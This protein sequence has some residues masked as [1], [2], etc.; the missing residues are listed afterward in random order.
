MVAGAAVAMILLTLTI[1]AVLSMLLEGIAAGVLA[2]KRRGQTRLALVLLAM[3]LCEPL[4]T[5]FLWGKSGSW[6]GATSFDPAE[7]P[8]LM[9]TAPA[10]MLLPPLTGLFFRAG[11]A[12]FFSARVLFV[13]LLRCWFWLYVFRI[14]QLPSTNILPLILAFV[15]MIPVYWLSAY[16]GAWEVM[17]CWLPRRAATAGAE[18]SAKAHAVAAVMLA[19]APLFAGYLSYP[20]RPMPRNELDRIERLP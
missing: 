2:W 1:P 4:V 12:R 8:W 11:W 7:I 3:N 17:I 10:A 20:G 13:G 18:P 5:A 15:L 14:M 19:L 9:V 16:W 6:H